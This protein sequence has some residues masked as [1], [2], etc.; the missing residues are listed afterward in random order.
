MLVKAEGC[1]PVLRAN[2]RAKQVSVEL[3]AG[4]C[5]VSIPA[6]QFKLAGKTEWKLN[7]A[8]A[9]RKGLENKDDLEVLFRK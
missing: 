2:I 9:I 1:F 3:L 7:E 6:I 4:W 5:G 8:I